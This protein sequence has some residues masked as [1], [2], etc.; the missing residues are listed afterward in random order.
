MRQAE[1]CALRNARQVTYKSA[2]VRSREPATWPFAL[3]VF[4]LLVGLFG[5]IAWLSWQGLV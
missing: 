4:A 5:G 2:E 3:S 1:Y